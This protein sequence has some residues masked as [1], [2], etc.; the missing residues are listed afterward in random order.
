MKKLLIG[1]LVILLALGM[2]TACTKKDDKK[3]EDDVTTA[4][5]VKTEEQ[6]L[7]AASKDGTWIICPLNDITIS[8][9]IVVEGEFHDKDD[10]SL[11]LYRKLGFYAQDENRN[12]TERYTVT[13]P[14]MIIKSP[15]TRLQGGT[16][17]G[18]VYVE[19]NGFNIVD[20]TVDG[21]VYFAKQEY[22]DSFKLSE[23][24][25]K[26]GKVTGETKVQE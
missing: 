26:E 5:L 3:G 25:G 12:V 23:D 16:F 14:K 19:A 9:D 17:K 20:G 18:D 7:K 2:F 21:N 4:S 22:M 24:E 1:T 13:A 11:D 15:N 10:E 8:K 6:F